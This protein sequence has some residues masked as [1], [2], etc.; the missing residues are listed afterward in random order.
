MVYGANKKKSKFRS[1]FLQPLSIVEMDVQHIPGKDIQSVKDVRIRF[2]FTG[3]PFDPVK[4]SLAIFMAEVLYR[5]LKRADSDEN[6]FDF[7]EKSVEALDCC[8]HGLSNF[9][10]VFLLG[11]TRFLG[12]DPNKSNSGLAYFDLMNG[13]FCAQRPMHNHFLLPEMTSVF[14]FSLEMDYLTMGNLRLNR[15]IRYKL[16]ESVIEYYRLHVPDF[17]GLNSLAVLHTLFD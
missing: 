3:I 5:S 16:I 8:E 11:L 15:D 9:H 14:S 10:I 7:I 12:F 1:A 17:Y 13:E 6:M 2:P 4:N